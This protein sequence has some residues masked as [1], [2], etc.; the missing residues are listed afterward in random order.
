MKNRVALWDNLKFVL[1]LLVVVGH[2]AER[3]APTSDVCKSIFLFIYA[4]HMPLFLFISGLFHSD[5]QITHKILFYISAGFALKFALCIVNW[6]VG[7]EFSFQLLADSYLPWFM[8][9]LAAYILLCYLLR[10][11]NKTY[12][13]VG[14]VLLAC[15][16]GY[17]PSV[18]D[19][20]YLSRIIVFFPFYLLGNLMNHKTIVQWRKNHAW[21]I[22]PAVCILLV[23]FYCCFAQLDHFYLFRR[24]F[25]GRNSFSD[26]F[27]STGL[28]AR[29]FCYAVSGLTCF[30]VLFLM[31]CKKIPFV[32]QAGQH[33]LNV[34]FWHWPFYLLLDHYLG[35][36]NWFS[37][38]LW[39]KISFFML[40]VVLTVILSACPWFSCPLKQIKRAVYQK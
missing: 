39:G 3:F 16:S 18:G 8:F 21:L 38:G 25:T 35:V 5:S 37:L 2:F 20:L 27:A 17:D 6:M 10:D 26:V 28:L 11:Q 23:W 32:S 33:T 30:A 12:I 9:A 4:F 34:Y 1:I 7:K 31:P 15:F 14:F 40:A 24:L 13:L 29:L 19:Y 36:S 22:L